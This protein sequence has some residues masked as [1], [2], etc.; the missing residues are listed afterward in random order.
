MPWWAPPQRL[1][2][3]AAVVVATLGAVVAVQGFLAGLLP[4]TLTYAAS[5]MHAGTLAQ[6]VVF[7]A[8]ALSAFRPWRL[9]SWP[10]VGVGA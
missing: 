6:G 3:R 2:R 4:Q 8:V 1:D 10:T 7:G 5:Q 9:S